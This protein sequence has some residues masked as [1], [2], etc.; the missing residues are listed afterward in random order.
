MAKSTANYSL[1]SYDD[2]STKREPK[3]VRDS[4]ALHHNNHWNHG[5]LALIVMF[6]ECYKNYYCYYYWCCLFSY[7]VSSEID[8]RRCC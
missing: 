6:N 7:C 8:L 3:N 1:R 5:M 4:Q 2:I